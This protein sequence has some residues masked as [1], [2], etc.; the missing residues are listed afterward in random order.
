MGTCMLDRTPLVSMI[1]TEMSVGPAWPSPDKPGTLIPADFKPARKV[2]KVIKGKF[3]CE[4]L[5]T[6]VP[7][8]GRPFGK[9]IELMLMLVED[10][11]ASFQSVAHW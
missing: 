5:G 8:A 4:A 1:G 6:V 3:C 11:P 10:C 9:K 7:A 2:A